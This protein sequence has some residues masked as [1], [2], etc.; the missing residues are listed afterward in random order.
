MKRILFVALMLFITLFAAATSAKE[1]YPQALQGVKPNR[2]ADP[3]S[4]EAVLQA[5]GRGANFLMERQNRNGSWGAAGR[6]KG[7]NIT[8]PGTSHDAFRAGTTALCL[9]ALL[10]IEAASKRNEHPIDQTI[11]GLA[12]VDLE[13]IGI[14]RDRLELCIEKAEWWTRDHLPKLR[15]SAPEALYNIWGHAYGLHSLV[16]MYRRFPDDKER[17]A[18]IVEIARG[19]VEMLRRFETLNGGWYY[20]DDGTSPPSQTTASFV[21]ATGLIALKEA[22]EIGVDIPQKMI[23]KTVKSIQRQR[24]PDFS[25]LYGE[26]L[27]VAPRSGINRPAGSLGRSQA[28]NLALRIWGDKAVTDDIMVN[29]LNRLYARNG[30]LDI[31]RKRPIPHESFFAIAGYFFYYGHFYASLCIEV[32]PEAERPDFKN[33]LADVLLGLQEKD[34]SWWDYPLYDYHQQYGT[35]FAILSLLRTF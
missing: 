27:R 21:S 22:Y 26:Y 25:Y 35:G 23:D 32:I 29:W 6:T 10:E 18:W 4:R 1:E 12:S 20:Y 16:R 30:W 28:C 13:E 33:F 15:R 8:A 11:T 17:Q 14:D 7:L 5:I 34:G 9:S 3:P 19:Q 2:L 24:L 31:G